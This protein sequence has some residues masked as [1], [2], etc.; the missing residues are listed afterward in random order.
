MSEEDFWDKIETLPDD[1]KE[2]EAFEQWLADGSP[3]LKRMFLR[4]LFLEKEND[5]LLNE[6]IDKQIAISIRKTLKP[7]R[8]HL[9]LTDW[10]TGVLLAV[11]V[12]LALWRILKGWLV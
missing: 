11:A 12:V 4:N 9:W 8:F 5:F 7:D 2:I 6:V 1:P 3:D 10:R